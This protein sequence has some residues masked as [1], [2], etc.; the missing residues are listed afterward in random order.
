MFRRTTLLKNICPVV[1]KKI[2]QGRN[3]LKKKTSQIF[4][5]RSNKTLYLTL[6]F[7][8]IFEFFL[9][10]NKFEGSA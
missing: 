7:Y 3:N 2:N 1:V 8:S 5:P 6:F 4:R 9:L 10:K